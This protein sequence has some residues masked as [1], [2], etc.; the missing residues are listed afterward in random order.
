MPL[1]ELAERAGITAPTMSRIERGD[2]SVGLGVA[3]EAATIV[4]V[5]LFVEEP[6]RLAPELRRQRDLIAL[7]PERA[8]RPR[9]TDVDDAF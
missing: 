5:P 7:L 6:S 9:E 8:R 4:G 1:R 3:F 2:P